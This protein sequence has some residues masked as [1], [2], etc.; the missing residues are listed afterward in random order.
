MPANAAREVEAPILDGAGAVAQR[1]ERDPEFRI[2]PIGIDRRRHLPGGIPVEVET[3][4][5]AGLRPRLSLLEHA[6]AF[7][8]LHD[9][10][11]VLDTGW[12][13]GK[14]EAI[15]PVEVRVEDDR[16]VIAVGERHIADLFAGHDA[17]RLA[18]EE[19][20]T[21]IERLTV[22]EQ[23][24]LGPFAHRFT[25]TQF[26]LHKVAVYL[27]RLP[28]LVIELAIDERRPGD[29]R[30][31]ASTWTGRSGTGDNLCGRF[32]GQHEYQ[33][34]NGRC[35]DVHVCAGWMGIRGDM[36]GWGPLRRP[37]KLSRGTDIWHPTVARI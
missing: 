37:T 28:C 13:G 7:A 32:T 24:H 2:P 22:G 3:A 31:R 35:V 34:K 17:G 36:A 10:A 9:L 29:D 19:P 1:R 20:C 33:G 14:D 8:L 21:D 4:H 23:P 11:V 18:V 25:L 16:E 6:A 26:T 12:R 30:R 27:A 15:L 5:R